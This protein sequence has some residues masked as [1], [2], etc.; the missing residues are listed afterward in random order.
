MR[1]WSD[2]HLERTPS[3]AGSAVCRPRPLSACRGRGS[4][5]RRAK[6][7][8][9]AGVAGSPLIRLGRTPW[10]AAAPLT[11]KEGRPHARRLFD[12]AIQSAGRPT[13]QPDAQPAKG[14][15]PVLEIDSLH[16][17][18]NGRP[19]LREFRF[20]PARR[21]SGSHGTQWVGQEHAAQAHRRA[22]RARL[23]PRSGGRT[24]YSWGLHRRHHPL[25]RLCAPTAQRPAFSGNAGR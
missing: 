16:Y 15:A 10:L 4:H 2:R 9:L 20:C 6:G 3:R 23:G 13:A 1:T 8:S 5:P 21:V 22:D 18:Y 17:A 19:A 14:S 24:R 7:H 11:I 25:R 12:Q